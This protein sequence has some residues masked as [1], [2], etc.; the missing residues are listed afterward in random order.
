VK[1]GEHSRK[2]N[3]FTADPSGCVKPAECSPGGAA[4][5]YVDASNLVFYNAYGTGAGAHSDIYRQPMGTMLWGFIG[6]SK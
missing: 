5:N 4:W 6:D 3:F 1:D 2:F